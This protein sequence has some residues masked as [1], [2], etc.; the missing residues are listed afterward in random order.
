MFLTVT[1]HLSRE[2]QQIAYSD[3]WR[4]SY[5]SA[6]HHLFYIFFATIFINLAP[7]LRYATEIVPSP[8]SQTHST[9]LLNELLSQLMTG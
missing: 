3:R 5:R 8:L 6:I 9:A 2:N 4:V 1:S 7:L